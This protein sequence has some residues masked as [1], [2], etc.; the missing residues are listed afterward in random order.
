ML[1]AALLSGC[2]CAFWI[3]YN[4]IIC[5]KG[6]VVADIWAWYRFSRTLFT[7]LAEA[8]P[9]RLLLLLS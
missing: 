6:L 9:A 7:R 8:A 2:S 5:E 3:I 1:T 4:Q